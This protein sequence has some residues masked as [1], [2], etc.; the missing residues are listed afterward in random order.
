MAS[1]RNGA[2]GCHNAKFAHWR[3]SVELIEQKFNELAMQVAF[4]PQADNL[5]V[6]RNDHRHSI[7]LSVG[8]RKTCPSSNGLVVERGAALFFAQGGRGSVAIELYPF[9]SELR[10]RREHSILWREVGD[11]AE[12]TEAMLDRAINDFFC[13]ARVS[14]ASRRDVAPDRLRIAYLLAKSWVN[15]KVRVFLAV[16]GYAAR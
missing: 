8:T 4:H 9:V 6:A 12:I 14:S 16:R 3:A 13:Y 5:I 11:P 10:R 7:R 15:R 1:G 2:S